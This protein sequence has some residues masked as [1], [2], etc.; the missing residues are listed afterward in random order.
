MNRH[1]PFLLL[2]SLLIS[3]FSVACSDLPAMGV[4]RSPAPTRTLS[5]T[6]SATL[7]P[8]FVG[9]QQ[10]AQAGA[11]STIASGQ[12]EMAI[13]ALTATIVS[14]EMTRA[15]ATDQR[16]AHQTAQA[17][18]ATAEADRRSVDSTATAQAAQHTATRQAVEATAIAQASTATQS[19]YDSQVTATQRAY[20]STATIQAI[21][22][23]I[24]ATATQAALVVIQAQAEADARSIARKSQQEAQTQIWRTWSGRFFWAAVGVLFFGILFYCLWT[25]RIAIFA[26]LGL[27]RWGPG[28]KPF[29]MVP[30]PAGLV[31]L[32]MTRSITPAQLV[33]NNSVTAL[34]GFGDPRLQTEAA[35]RSQ[36]AELLLA[37]NT[38]ETDYRRI[39][40]RQQAALKQAAQSGKALP[41]VIQS[42]PLA[43]TGASIELPAVAPWSMVDRWRGR[44]LPLGVSQAGLVT[45]DPERT[46]HLLIAGTS[47]SGKTMTGLRPIAAYA[48]ACGYRVILLNDAGGDFAPLQGHPNLAVVDQTP[49]AIA[50]ALEYVAGEVARRSEILRRA[51]VSTWLRLPE[52]KR[53]EP[54]IMVVID[55]L[56]ALAIT[57]DAHTRE[58]IW[59]ACIQITTKGRKMDIAFVAATTDPTYRTLGKEGLIVRDNCGRIAF[60]M[61]DE[62]TSR[63]MLDQSGAE[64]LAENQ[65]LAMLNGSLVQGVAFH[66]QDNDL[67]DFLDARPVA[68]LPEV[69]WSTVKMEED[70]E[71][72]SLANQVK[73][74]WERKASKS[75]MAR[76]VGKAYGGAFYDKL[77]RAVAWLDSSSTSPRVASTGQ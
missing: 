13:V 37:A 46:P 21:N 54:P 49:E 7:I 56:V 68:A 18:T 17:V 38:H 45:A 71:I 55:E 4:T 23:S 34:G 41:V 31:L 10:S 24:R 77:N 43:T 30:T 67:V 74:L 62:S 52:E 5:P 44:S 26:R 8:P 1:I 69:T 16:A 36:A 27:I 19:A 12:A 47:G 35:A 58:R 32:D 3:L 64:S 73:P 61:R 76:E 50:N 28:G 65:F 59:R 22:S 6:P 72:V 33:T 39:A 11:Q 2:I 25:F 66:P 48:L 40:Q 29:V 15:A 57:A 9:T 14:M 42:A 70:P 63:A 51:G 53:Q 75:E 60:R 20:E